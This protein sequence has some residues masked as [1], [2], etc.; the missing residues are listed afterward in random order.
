MTA[1]DKFH[2]AVKLALEKEQWVITADPLKF[3]YGGVKFRIDLSADRLLAADRE[4]EKIAIE[5]KSFLNDSPLTDFHGALG[6]FQ[7]Y[8]SALRKT[9]PDRTLYLAVP[10]GVYRSFF[11]F[12]FIQ[13]QIEEHRLLLIV[14]DADNE[15]IVQWIA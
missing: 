12:Q 9:D 10:L 15:V 13:E 11:Q 6:Q 3:K 8:R 14:Y 4:N 5:I 2:E 7:N 1:K